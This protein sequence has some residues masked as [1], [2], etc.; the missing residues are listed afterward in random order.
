MWSAALRYLFMFVLLL[1]ILIQKK[2][3]SFCIQ[4]IKEAPLTWILYS[5][6]GFGL[7]YA[8]LTFASNYGQSWLVA[9]CWQLT[10]LAGILLTPLFGKKLPVKSL[11]LSALIIFGVFLIQYEQASTISVRQACLSILPILV[12]AFAYPL[13]NRKMME[14]CDGRLSTLER[15]FTMT[16]CSL[17]FWIILSGFAVTASGLPGKSQIFQSFIVALMSGV[18]ATILFFKATELTKHNSHQLAIIEATQAGEVLF[19]ILGELL[20]LHGSMPNAI[21]MIGL[22]LIILGMVLGSIFGQTA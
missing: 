9:G 4:I 15:V 19:S 3:L 18:I 6:I 7:F 22:G 8:P 10:I 2:R 16:L 1:P 11:L 21:G 17:P 14:V 20:L 12:A 13:G 5:T